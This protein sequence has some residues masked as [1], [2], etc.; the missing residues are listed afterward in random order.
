M[1]SCLLERIVGPTFDKGRLLSMSSSTSSSVLS[2]YTSGWS[3]IPTGDSR[4]EQILP[5]WRK[6]THHLAKYVIPKS[7]APLEVLRLPAVMIV[8]KTTE[9][10]RCTLTGSK[11]PFSHERTQSQLTIRTH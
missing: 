1:P 4:N 10:R 8:G 7:D 9:Q 6:S 2:E 3:Q 5:R 11:S